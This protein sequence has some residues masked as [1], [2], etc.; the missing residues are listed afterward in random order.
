MLL[1]KQINMKEFIFN[2]FSPDTLKKAIFSLDQIFSL[3]RPAKFDKINR[4]LF[5]RL[6]DTYYKSITKFKRDLCC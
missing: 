6:D 5:I 4:N 3:R 2:Q 1:Y